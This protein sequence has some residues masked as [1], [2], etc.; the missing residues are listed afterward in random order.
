MISVDGPAEF[1]KKNAVGGLVHWEAQKEAASRFNMTVR[2]VEG[3]ILSMDHLPARYAKNR[4]II[5]TQQQRALFDGTVAVV[6]CGGL[7]GYVVEELARL[8]VGTLRV[9]D[10]DVFEEHNLNRQVLCTLSSLG[11]AKV[12]AA[13]DRVAGINPACEVIPLRTSLTA[14]NAPSL[15]S[16]SVAVVDG[17]DSIP[18]RLDL[19]DACARLRIPLVHGAIGGWYGM[20]LTQGPEQNR[21]RQLYGKAGDIRGIEET[22]GNPSFTPALVASIEAAEVCKLLIGEGTTLDGRMLFINLL[23]MTMETFQV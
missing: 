12:D 22:L 6:G 3:I 2:Q 15:L 9:I 10:A 4:A 8:G 20:V 11:K 7:G 14:D 18:S 21:I 17:L 13:A 16:G 5:N 19:A 1:L 23:D